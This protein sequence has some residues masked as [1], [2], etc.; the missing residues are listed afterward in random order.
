MIVHNKGDYVRHIG[1]RLI[2]GVN[3]LLSHQVKSFEK[4]SGHKLNKLLIE[5]GEIE[6]VGRDG[7]DPENANFADLNADQAIALANETFTLD[8]LE[9]FK[10]Q[11][12][13]GKKRSTVLKAIDEQIAELTSRPTDEDEE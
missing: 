2:P 7:E 10:E 3:K 11:E 4:A 1:V 12:Q 6:V 8:L 9:E 5:S 13:S